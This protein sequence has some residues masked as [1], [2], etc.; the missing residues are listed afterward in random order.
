VTRRL[1]L[2]VLASGAGTTFECVVDATRSGELPLDV[3][4]LVSDR[5]SAAA[6]ARAQALGIP[7]TVLD[8]RELGVDVADQQVRQALGDAQVDLVLLAGYIRKVGPETLGAFEGRMY[9]THPSLLPAFGGKGMYGDN[10]YAAV[11]E[12]GVEETGATVHLV[13]DEYDAGAIVAQ[14]RVAVKPGDELAPLRSRVQA[15]ERDL[16]LQVLKDVATRAQAEPLG[17]DD[18]GAPR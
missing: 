15:A 12:A 6:L 14:R 1:R 8:P 4:L 17:H 18:A 5:S 10:V 2:G 9:N 11:L 13:N 7:S 16:L 3:A